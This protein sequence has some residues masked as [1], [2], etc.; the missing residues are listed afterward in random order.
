MSAG[1]HRVP[2]E[3]A[4]HNIMVKQQFKQNHIRDNLY[5]KYKAMFENI[6]TR[7]GW[8]R[9]M[10]VTKPGRH[11]FGKKLVAYSYPSHYPT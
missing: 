2:F 1:K 5:F 11:C 7:R 3:W 4:D 8:V 9:H 10:C 6:L